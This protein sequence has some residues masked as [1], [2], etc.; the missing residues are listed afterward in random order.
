MDCKISRHV[1]E[2]L[3]SPACSAIPRGGALRV[4]PGHADYTARREWSSAA[5]A[6][7]GSNPSRLCLY[8]GTVSNRAGIRRVVR[9]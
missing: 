8:G 7:H 6:C 2:Q 9:P 4:A 5:R 1:S 3:S